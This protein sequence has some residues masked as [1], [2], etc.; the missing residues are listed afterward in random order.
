[1]KHKFSKIAAGGLAALAIGVAPLA[2]ATP[3]AAGDAGAAVAAGVGGF[4]LGAILGGAAHP[5]PYYY[6]A[7]AYYPAPVPYYHCWRARRPV[8]DE[9]GR[10][11]GYRPQRV[12]E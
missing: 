6:G 10:V 4:A 9:Y 8:F 3:A 7:P 5:A 2:S 12:C 11:I 1:M